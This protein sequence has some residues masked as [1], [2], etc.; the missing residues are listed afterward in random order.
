MV[1]FERVF[2]A[3]VPGQY[4][5]QDVSL[6]IASGEFVFL[7]GPSGAGKSTLLKL[8]SALEQPS[9]GRVQVLG[10]DVGRLPPRARPWLRRSIGVVLQDTWLLEDR[11][12]LENVMMPLLV[13][14]HARSEA[15]RRARAAIEKVGLSDRSRERP[16]NLSGG[17]QRRL[18][19]ARA[20]VNRPSLLIADEPTSN[21]DRANARKIMGVFRDFNRAGVTTLL[22][23][24]DES[25]LFEFATRIIALEGGRLVQNSPVRL[26]PRT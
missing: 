5:L 8:I 21:L 24:H 13:S 23:T 20:I 14:G 3:Y 16:Q 4:A 19:I 12:G 26:G 22:S 18:A 9:R 1:E 6:S 10:Q 7:A 15:E 2:K 11:S 17:E 25:I